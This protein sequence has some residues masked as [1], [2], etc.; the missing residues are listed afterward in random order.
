M[1]KIDNLFH[2]VFDWIWISASDPTKTS[3]T[4]KATLTTAASVFMTI[5]GFTHVN[6]GNDMV[7]GIV[8]A[9]NTV[10]LDGLIWVGAIAAAYGAIRKVWLSL[11][12]KNP[13]ISAPTV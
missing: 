6:I 13:V 3:L 5:V 10:V 1:Q 9:V 2:K 4:V 12:G 11:T 8:D 7:N